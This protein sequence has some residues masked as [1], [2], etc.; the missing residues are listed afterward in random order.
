MI[1]TDYRVQSILRTYTR[2][3]QRS[4]LAEK[5]NPESGDSRS[6]V[7]KVSISDEA[8][9]RMM[10]ER[11]TSRVFEK[12]YSNNDIGAESAE[13]ETGPEVAAGQER[14]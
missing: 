13:S 7:E 1:I 2:Q 10:M 4:K 5:L 3:L 8:R 14:V 9:R 12:V 6:S 11:L